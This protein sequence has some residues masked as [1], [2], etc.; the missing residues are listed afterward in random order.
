MKFTVVKG[1]YGSAEHEKPMKDQPMEEKSITKA[2][3]REST[4]KRQILS[5]PCSAH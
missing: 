2:R 3:K 5:F 4:E 1:I